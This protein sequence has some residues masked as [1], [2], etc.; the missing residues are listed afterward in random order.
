MQIGVLAVYRPQFDFEAAEHAAKNVWETVCLEA[1]SIAESESVWLGM[2]DEWQ[3]Q[4]Q[5]REMTETIRRL[6]VVVAVMGTFAGADVVQQVADL[7]PGTVWLWTVSEPEV[8]HGRLRLNSLC[9]GLLTNFALQQQGRSVPMLY[10]NPKDEDLRS[11]LRALL[12]VEKT[13]I[14][15]RSSTIGVVGK[16]PPGYFSCDYDGQALRRQL[17]VQVT[18]ISLEEAFAAAEQA[19]VAALDPGYEAVAGL[20]GWKTVEGSQVEQS[21]KAEYGLRQLIANHHLTSLTVECWPQYMTEFGGAVCW[22][23]SRLIDDQVMAGCEADVHGTLSMLICR[24]LGGMSPF[25]GDL[26]HQVSDDRLV[27]W[28]CGAAPLSLAGESPR[29]SVH[30]N[31][32]VGLT[33]DFALMGGPATVVRLHQDGTGYSL[34]AISGEAVDDDLYFSGNTA[35]VRTDRPAAQ[36]LADLVRD[37]AEHHF[38]VGYGVTVDSVQSLGSRLGIPV[39]VY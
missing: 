11:R 8:G 39:H 29:A 17:G 35:T 20:A 7:C 38:S 26:V 6:D 19:T 13:C 33:L 14:A 9:G 10:G 24:E 36:V 37:G 27:F 28:H 5:L 1:R 34:M 4:A 22:A 21:L 3:A 31:R 18:Q 30:P 16:H 32:K 2:V 23:M 15:L 12:M 25:F